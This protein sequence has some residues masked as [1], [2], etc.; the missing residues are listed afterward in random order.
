MSST[1]AET[2]PDVVPSVLHRL[3]TQQH[4]HTEQQTSLFTYDTTPTHIHRERERES[5]A[6]NTHIQNIIVTSYFYLPTT[7]FSDTNLN[8]C[9]TFLNT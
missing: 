1:R 3:D 2:E 7:N 5:T 6:G 4:T 9:G 8:Y